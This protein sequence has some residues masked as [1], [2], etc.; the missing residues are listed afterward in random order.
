MKGSQLSGF[1]CNVHMQVGLREACKG[2]SGGRGTRACAETLHC[3]TG[4]E[5]DS[6]VFLVNEACGTIWIGELS[7]S[8]RQCVGC[9]QRTR[10]EAF[11]NL[12]DL[13]PGLL[14][15][16]FFVDLRQALCLKPNH[17]RCTLQMNNHVTFRSLAS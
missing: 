11:H 7:G 1:A 6:N 16:L 13:L 3:S 15:L 9:G 8:A 12:D 4:M 10:R 2:S 17:N 14:V 5:G